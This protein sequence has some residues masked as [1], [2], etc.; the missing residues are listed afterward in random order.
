LSIKVL[1]VS[2]VLVVV[3]V[4]P[5]AAYNWPVWP[6][7]TYH[8]VSAHYGI[9]L[10][11]PG[12]PPFMHS[13]ID[14]AVPYLTPVFAMKS[15][16]VKTVVT[17]SD[18]YSMWRI[19]IGDSSGTEEC[20]AWM[21]AHLVSTSIAGIP[22]QYIEAGDSIGVVVNWP[23]SPTTTE[24]LHLSKIRYSGTNHA[25]S[26]GWD[27]WRYYDNPLE[28]LEPIN[29]TIPPE[30][31]P[32][33]GDQL[34]AFCTNQTDS[35]FAEGAPIS[36]DVDIIACIH[37]LH[38][39]DVFRS[40][41]YEVKYKI[42]GDS[43]IDWTRSVR[44]THE[45][46][47]Y[48]DMADLTETVYQDDATCNS[49]DAPGNTYRYYFNL[50]NS[51]GDTIIEPEHQA[52]GWNTVFFHNG[53]YEV[54]VSASDLGGNVTT[55]SMT[56]TVANEIL[57]SG[58]VG[59]SDSYPN[60]AGS[61]ISAAPCSAVDTTD[62]TGAFSLLC[63]GADQ[64]ITIERLGYATIDTVLMMTEERTLDV[65][66]EGTGFVCADID[67][68][69]SGPDIADL[70]YLVTYMFQNGPEPP[71]MRA[72]DIDGSGSY[73]DIADLVYLVTYMFQ[74]GPDPICS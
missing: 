47:S 45:H 71:L 23:S 64:T 9:Y 48:D 30:I 26:T 27:Y 54:F 24:H 67:Y 34:L 69:G 73:V 37:D 35:Y 39:F 53:D 29:D 6:D 38:N 36:G 12:E 13:G 10:Q 72:T 33:L 15:G 20:D 5:A 17:N 70:V 8:A 22:G 41:P 2:A 68:S 40:V 61:I 51:D 42:E 21:Y 44:F 28:F 32:A 52:L 60:L 18:S 11:N 63:G 66:L 16:W 31:T 25:W 74:N 49:F 4:S 56:I 46:G 59:L 62:E 19:I 14:I 50:T 43:S 3:A 1:I 65:V 57:L 55:D 7:S 58:T